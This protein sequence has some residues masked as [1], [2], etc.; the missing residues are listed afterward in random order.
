MRDA[1]GNK[2]D[3]EERDKITFHLEERTEATSDL[4]FRICRL[5]LRSVMPQSLSLSPLC[6][7]EKMESSLATTSDDLETVAEAQPRRCFGFFL[8]SLLR[9]R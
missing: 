8:D 6:S 1:W 4:S 3:R 2:T 5:H 9:E 7:C